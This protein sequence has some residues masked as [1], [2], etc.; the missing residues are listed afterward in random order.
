[1]FLDFFLHMHFWV[2]IVSQ[3]WLT[4]TLSVLHKLLI[5]KYFC[6]YLQALQ[7]AQ[8]QKWCRL[9]WHCVRTNLAISLGVSIIRFTLYRESLHQ[10]FHSYLRPL[11]TLRRPQ[12][13]RHIKFL[14]T[15]TFCPEHHETA[16]QVWE[17]RGG[18]DCT[19]PALLTTLTS[20]LQRYVWRS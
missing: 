14:P 10:F 11:P 2:Q 12:Q 8:V 15:Q 1:M 7:F 5:T 6:S 20:S 3:D 19:Y 4:H 16:R 17:L 9:D 18:V 13:W